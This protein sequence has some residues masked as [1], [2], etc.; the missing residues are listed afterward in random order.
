MCRGNETAL[1]DQRE[2]RGPAWLWARLKDQK[3]WAGCREKGQLCGAGVAVGV[4]EQFFTF[5]EA[6][7]WDWI[8]LVSSQSVENI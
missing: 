3:E 8:L 5:L 6:P 2:E 4:E 7:A 1:K